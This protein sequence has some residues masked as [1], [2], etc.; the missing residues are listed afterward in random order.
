MYEAKSKIAPIKV[1]SLPRLE[2][3]GALLSA[4]LW[5]KVSNSLKVEPKVYFWTDSTCVLQWI[6][7]PPGTWTT[8]VANRVAKIQAL[9]EDHTWSH[10]S[11]I[12]N[13]A[14]LISRG[15]LPREMCKNELW[16][17][18]PQWLKKP[19]DQ[20]ISNP[21]PQQ[22]AQEVRRSVVSCPAENI[23]SFISDYLAKFSDYNKI[24]RSTAYWL[25]LLQF[26][27]RNGEEKRGFLTTNELQEAENLITRQVQQEH[28]PKEIKA[29]KE[30]CSVARGSPLRWFNPRIT[31]DGILRVGGRLGHS[32]ESTAAKHP[33][34]LPANHH[35]TVLILR[36]YHQR[37]LHAGPQ[38]LLAAVRQRF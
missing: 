27:K 22:P 35:L 16:W 38:L 11:G 6:K 3:C 18:G 13:P 1:Q 25:R 4:Q 5:E 24:I 37:L 12:T 17:F 15:I 19:K 14:D 20:W 31:E 8:F 26:L 10:V 30:G 34:V 2:L 29:L 28:F 9:T 32:N 23:T 7:S 33:M 21:I 36:N